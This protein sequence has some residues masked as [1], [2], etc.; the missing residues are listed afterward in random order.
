MANTL[1]YQFRFH[2]KSHIQNC[3][4]RLERC[5]NNCLSYIQRKRMDDH[6]RECRILSPEN[7]PP[8]NYDNIAQTNGRSPDE[9]VT[10][11]YPNESEFESKLL[12]IEDN[13][14]ALRN[15]L[16]EEIRQRHRLITDVGEVRKQNVATDEWSSKINDILDG[17]KC[18]L[19]DESK[20]RE[21][22]IGNCRDE[23]ER[24]ESQYQ[25]NDI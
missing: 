11:F 22:A 8:S 1:I 12:D 4:Q 5:P 14:V 20:T 10:H 7:V 6:L 21:N 23:I 18:C 9:G 16:N 13:I 2:F 15:A 17:L 24:I 25:V 3:G 19:N